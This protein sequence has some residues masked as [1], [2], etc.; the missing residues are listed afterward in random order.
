M[1]NKPNFTRGLPDVEAELIRRQK[2]AEAGPQPHHLH[3]EDHPYELPAFLA[4][5]LDDTPTNFEEWQAR[6]QQ[7]RS[8]KNPDERGRN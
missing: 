5:K 8:T 3:A 6:I 7:G 1:T 2:A 4:E